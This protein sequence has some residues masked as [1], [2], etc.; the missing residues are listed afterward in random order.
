MKKFNTE[1]L[2]SSLL[3]LG[4]EQVDSLLYTYTLGKISLEQRTKQEFDFEEQELT[5]HFKEIVCLENGAYRLRDGLTLSSNI[6]PLTEKNYSIQKYLTMK[7]YSFFEYL[8][9]FD[10][11][12][13]ILRIT[14]ELPKQKPFNAYL[15]KPI[16]FKPVEI[17][18][19]IIAGQST[20]GFIPYQAPDDRYEVRGIMPSS[21]NKTLILTPPRNKENK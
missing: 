17:D 11:S 3:A 20:G 18:D 6:S 10:F 8:S 7:N 19:Y 2:I 1:D 5:Q 16:G 21:K 13:I 12:E 15:W 9:S 14:G 4:F